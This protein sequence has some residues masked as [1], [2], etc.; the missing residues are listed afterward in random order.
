MN[1]ALQCLLHT[2]ELSKY[3]LLGLHVK[4]I[5]HVNV[6]GSKGRVAERYGEL[7]LDV[8]KGNGM[9]VR[10]YDMKEILGGVNE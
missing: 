9:R 6:M 4:E 1:A 3:F 10:P 2:T 5:N 8:W 7:C